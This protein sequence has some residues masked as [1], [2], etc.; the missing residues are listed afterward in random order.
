MS[1]DEDRAAS[2]RTLMV[3]DDDAVSLAVLSLLL[4]AEGYEVMQAPGGSEAI[5]I[6]AGLKI[7][8]L[9]S[10]LLADLQMP[11]ICGAELANA[12]RTLAPQSILLA[13]SA[14]PDKAEG[15]D[16]FLNK[17]LD[18]SVLRT[19]IETRENAAAPESAA[20]ATTTEATTGPAILDEVIYLRLLRAMPPTAVSEIYTV[21][22]SDARARAAG[23][24]K[25]ATAG[26][27][28]GIR[29]SAH[30]IK[31][32]AGMVGARKLAA[33]AAE[34]ELGSYRIEDIPHLVDNI[35]FCCDQLQRILLEKLP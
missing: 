34:L 4:Q 17:P 30:T 28:E 26:D 29:Q 13:M 7:D 3:I 18:L 9:P 21:C 8:S 27:L 16:G 25:A 19:A 12:L 14:T 24:R 11:G 23:M 35:L 5:H 33:A 22:L 20:A 6:L 1:Y 10:V 31:G 2:R 32:G 15:Y